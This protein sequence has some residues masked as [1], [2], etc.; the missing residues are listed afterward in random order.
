MLPEDLALRKAIQWTYLPSQEV[1]RSP[2]PGGRT[3]HLPALSVHHRV[4]ITNRA[5]V[6]HP[7]KAGRTGAGGLGPALRR[8]Q[9][10]RPPKTR[11]LSWTRLRHLT[12]LM[13]DCRIDMAKEQRGRGG[14][15][16]SRLV[17]CASPRKRV[18]VPV[19]ATNAE[20]LGAGGRDRPPGTSLFT[21]AMSSAGPL[22]GRCQ[23][24]SGSPRSR[25]LW[26]RGLL[27]RLPVLL[28]RSRHT[29]SPRLGDL[30]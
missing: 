2:N 10:R 22:A 21:C 7:Q 3:E 26:R 29:P 28:S 13:A 1:P 24:R 18:C 27:P 19:F 9:A 12:A 14:R 25:E 16:R 15:S 4:R 23:T 6:T 5:A 8:K 30:R 20:R 11:R 17:P